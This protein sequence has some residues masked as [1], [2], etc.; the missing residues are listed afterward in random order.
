MEFP[1]RAA[2]YA[3]QPR[4]LVRHTSTNVVFEGKPVV[5][6]HPGSF[7]SMAPRDK[8]P[9]RHQDPKTSN[10]AAIRRGRFVEASTEAN[11][12][13]G[14]SYSM[15]TMGAICFPVFSVI[16]MIFGI[17]D[18]N[19]LDRSAFWQLAGW[20]C[21]TVALLA[22]GSWFTITHRRTI[23]PSTFSAI[24]CGTFLLILST[25]IPI[26]LIYLEELGRSDRL[27]HISLFTF[28]SLI[29]YPGSIPMLV[30]QAASAV[31]SILAIDHLAGI[32]T[33]N[34]ANDCLSVLIASGTAV[35]GNIIAG[36][37]SREAYLVT[38]KLAKSEAEL[39]KLR[40][41]QAQSAEQALERRDA[42]WTAMVE[43]APVLVLIV[44]KTG[45][46]AFANHKA[47]ALGFRVGDLL[48]ISS[49]PFD[50]R[51][52][53]AQTEPV[54]RDAT[55]RSFDVVLGEQVKDSTHWTFYAAPVGKQT[56][57]E[58]ITLVGIDSTEAWRLRSELR[59][60]SREN[61]L[62]GF[63]T[64]LSHDF[65]NLL[66][67]IVGSVEILALSHRNDDSSNQLIRSI[68]DASNRADELIRRILKF[69]R[70][71]P[72]R[73][74]IH[75]V[76]SLI[77]DMH[78]LL[79]YTS[80][81][82]NHFT[83]SPYPEPLRIRIDKTEFEQILVNLCTNANSAIQGTGEI[84]ISTALDAQNRVQ[85]S[86]KDNGCGIPDDV[87]RQMFEPYFTTRA[88]YGGSGIGLATVRGLVESAGG[89]VR[90][91]STPDEGTEMLIT[92]ERASAHAS[93]FTIAAP[94]D[95]ELRVPK[96]A[97]VVDENPETR[98]L[99]SSMLQHMGCTT[100]TASSRQAA[101]EQARAGQTIDLL[102]TSFRHDLDKALSLEH[103]VRTHHPKVAAV[104]STGHIDNLS[105]LESIQDEHLVVLR[106]P[107]TSTEMANAVDEA[108]GDAH[109]PRGTTR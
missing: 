47:V 80:G 36:S 103:A 105:I 14:R 95:P 29:L 8:S 27:L 19:L 94:L 37:R 60:K 33:A 31:L 61:S 65:N 34:V 23:R 68:L 59:R 66:M 2:D 22:C 30:S 44:D 38:L 84:A 26:S 25:N 58:Q 3:D 15:A 100:F 75:E 70:G 106:K 89:Q 71:A 10:P 16:S 79:R 41:A 102:V 12:L 56:P 48:K 43:Q 20:R 21:V 97:L 72:S 9:L 63:V 57:S 5:A 96:T 69:V 13:Q 49:N 88:E 7:K 78:A 92:L 108:L 77:Q 109:A 40:E 11:F 90:V 35:A 104:Y 55:T 6:S 1:T 50:G 91:R 93:A 54:F 86:V 17:V 18:Y 46:V 45:V 98:S 52:L 76:N 32:S 28:I 4:R 87:K 82:H 107:Y 73:P 53:H 81:A 39:R 42:Q 64:S 74:E 62:G 101:I 24:I 85:I 51:W 67:V 83:F 99:A